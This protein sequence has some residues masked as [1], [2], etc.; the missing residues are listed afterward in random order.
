MLQLKCAEY[1]PSLSLEE[2]LF[3]CCVKL[4]FIPIMD[5]HGEIVW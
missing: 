2:V 5:F 4:L 3:L 1:Q